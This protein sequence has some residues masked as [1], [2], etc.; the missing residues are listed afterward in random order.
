ME[1]HAKRLALSLECLLLECKDI[2]AVSKWWDSSHAALTEYQSTIDRLYPQEHVSPLGSG[3]QQAEPVVVI[4]PPVKLKYVISPKP[5]CWDDAMKWAADH[6]LR[7]ATV[8]E[9]RRMSLPT[10]YYWS[11]T[12]YS[13]S[14][15]W[16]FNTPNGFQNRGV[17]YIALFAVAVAHKQAINADD[18]QSMSGNPSY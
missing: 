18:D 17:K 12:E 11:G 16:L 3:E 8:D 10:D 5:M 2:A 15:A 7:L 4:S 1:S 6:G 14:N 9:M 13:Q